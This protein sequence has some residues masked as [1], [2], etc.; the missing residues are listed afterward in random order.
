M[1]VAG[2]ANVAVLVVDA[3]VESCRRE[4]C[5]DYNR[6]ERRQVKGKSASLSR[7]KVISRAVHGRLSL[8]L[9]VIEWVDVTV[10]GYRQSWR[11]LRASYAWWNVG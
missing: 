2:A 4:K 11:S 5:N 1:V 9:F 10:L 3:I 6:S 8:S 7:N